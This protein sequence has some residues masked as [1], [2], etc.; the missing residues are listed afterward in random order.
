M[1]ELVAEWPGRAIA[2]ARPSRSIYRLAGHR[3]A[4]TPAL[5]EIEGFRDASPTST[6][7]PPSAWS[8]RSGAG[9]LVYRG[10]TWIGQRERATECRRTTEGLVIDLD[11]IGR[12][13]VA[14]D[15][16]SAGLVDPGPAMVSDTGPGLLAETLL[17]RP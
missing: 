2:S 5:P 16:R 3:V 8:G 9:V 7:P 6:D 13:Q 10:A 11:G 12:L 4:V 1:I 17:G 14:A 15:G